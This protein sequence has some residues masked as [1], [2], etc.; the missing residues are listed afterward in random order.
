MNG[1]PLDFYF[2]FISPFGYFA[3]LRIDEPARFCVPGA[4]HRSSAAYS[5]PRRCS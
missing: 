5:A 3:A 2:D 4:T 1:K